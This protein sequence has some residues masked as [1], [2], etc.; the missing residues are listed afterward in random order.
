MKKAKFILVVL[1]ISVSTM[2]FAQSHHGHGGG[3][4]PIT[5]VQLGDVILNLGVGVGADYKGDDYNTGFGTKIA[6][7]KAMWQAGPGVI[8]LGGELGGSWSSGGYNGYD[9]YH[10]STIVAAARA[11]WHYGW[12]VPGLDTY[13]GVSA[14]LGFHHLKYDP[15]YSHSSVIPAPGAFV[16]ASY[17]VTPNFGFNAEAGYDIT[18]VQIGLVFKLM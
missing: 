15:N 11:A 4:G 1:G 6:I 7:E 16:G 9:N 18:A 2:T 13:G 10:S 5:P 8:T 12:Q 14:G 17:F 3:N